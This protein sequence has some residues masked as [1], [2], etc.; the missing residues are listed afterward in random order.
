M[1]DTWSD[2]R[3]QVMVLNAKLGDL[4]AEISHI[5]LA[6]HRL[7]DVQFDGIPGGAAERIADLYRIIDDRMNGHLQTEYIRTRFL[8]GD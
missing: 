7:G 8:E 2:L 5:E 3:K 1:T 4:S 6:V